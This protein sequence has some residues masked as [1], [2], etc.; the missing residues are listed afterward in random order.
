MNRWLL[1]EIRQ[2][3]QHPLMS[4]QPQL[5]PHTRCAWPRRDNLLHQRSIPRLLDLQQCSRLR[6]SDLRSLG[7]GLR[8]WSEA[9]SFAV[10]MQAR[11][12]QVETANAAFKIKP[13]VTFRSLTVQE[14]KATEL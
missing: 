14:K 12:S 5:T 8:V 13:G 7:S 6:A 4:L 10:S 2:A 3:P 1:T 9:L 11:G